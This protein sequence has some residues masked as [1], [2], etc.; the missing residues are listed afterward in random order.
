MIVDRLPNPSRYEDWR[1]WAKD[2][3]KLAEQPAT[4]QRPSPTILLL[5]H[6]SGGESA[7]IDGLVMFD[8]VQGC[9]VYSHNGA[10]HPMTIP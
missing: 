6:M 5:R 4:N 2:L 9:P 7:A 8:P 1:S 3:V 10:W